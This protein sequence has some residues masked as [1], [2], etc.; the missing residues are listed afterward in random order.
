MR[1]RAERVERECKECGGKFEVLV[2]SVRG[3]AHTGK[4]CS[5]KC[6]GKG[7]VGKGKKRVKPYGSPYLLE[8]VKRRACLKCGGMFRSLGKFNRVCKDCK[9]V[10]SVMY[11]VYGGSRFSRITNDRNP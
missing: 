7:K 2:S 5:I 1:K 11:P 9:L 6:A 8:E 3:G 10:N 4:Y